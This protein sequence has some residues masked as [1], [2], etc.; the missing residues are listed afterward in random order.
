MFADKFSPLIS[1]FPQDADALRRVAGYFVGIEERHGNGVFKVKLDPK[2]LF[3]ISQ[4]GSA[5][6]LAR[7]IKI[8]IDGHILQRRIVVRSPLGGGIEFRS[9]ADL[10]EIIRDPLRDVDMEV[11]VENTEPI[12]VVAVDE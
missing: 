1:S 7:I 9:Y 8:L 2:R 11:T 12:Y 10:P 6:R 3:D 5:T 4:A